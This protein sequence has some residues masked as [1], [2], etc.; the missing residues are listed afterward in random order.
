MAKP[1]FSR[2]SGATWSITSPKWIGPRADCC[3]GNFKPQVAHSGCFGRVPT[4]RPS[5]TCRLHWRWKEQKELAGTITGTM[6]KP[7][8][9]SAQTRDTK[10]TRAR[11]ATEEDTMASLSSFESIFA[12][13]FDDESTLQLIESPSGLRVLDA[14]CGLGRQAAKL[15][16]RGAKLVCVDIDPTAVDQTRRRLDPEHQVFLTDLRE[17][18]MAFADASFDCVLAS[19]VLHYIRDWDQPLSE[20][21]RILR[22][23]GQLLVSLHHPFADYVESQSHSYEATESWVYAN[24][25]QVADLFWRRP[26]AD[27]L[28]SL[29]DAGFVVEGLR[30]PTAV[31]ALPEQSALGGVPRLLVVSARSPAHAD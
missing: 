12:S 3:A 25:G 26:L 22:P 20:F 10:M 30:E 19:L 11:A 27:V 15:A 1:S 13:H 16:S 9:L 8:R 6:H 24:Y 23:S 4:E 14:G 28:S 17:P 2:L 31:V 18:M 5:P 21:K 7:T 29:I